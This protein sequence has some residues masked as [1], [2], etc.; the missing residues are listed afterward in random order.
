MSGWTDGRK[1]RRTNVGNFFPFYGTLSPLRAAAQKERKK[2]LLR[3]VNCDILWEAR[4]PSEASVNFSLCLNFSLNLTLTF[5]LMN[6]LKCHPTDGLRPESISQ[7]VKTDRKY[8]PELHTKVSLLLLPLPNR[9]SFKI[10]V[11]FG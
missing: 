8:L 9:Q 2:D 6:E 10:F 11:R 5:P 3:F 4:K 7:N 1:E